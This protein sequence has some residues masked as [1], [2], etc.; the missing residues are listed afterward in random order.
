QNLEQATF[1]VALAALYRADANEPAKAADDLFVAFSLADSLAHIPTTLAQLLRRRVN[2]CALDALEET[3]NRCL[4]SADDTAN[5]FRVLKAMEMREHRGEF[6]DR[7]LA[8]ERAMSLAA[9]EHP[10]QLRRALEAPD[11]RLSADRRHAVASRLRSGQ[12]LSAE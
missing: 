4:L 1:L 11:L 9:L 5:V 3:V 7:A 6:L 8:G 2:G 12:P 10:Q